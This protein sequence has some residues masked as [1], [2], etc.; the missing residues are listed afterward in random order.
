MMRPPPPPPPQTATVYDVA[1]HPRLHGLGIGR[2]LV[3]TIVAQLHAMGIYDIGAVREMEILVDVPPHTH[4]GYTYRCRLTPAYWSI[5]TR[6][7]STC[8]YPQVG[9][10]DLQNFFSRCSFGEDS[11]AS[12]FMAY[13]G[14]RD[15]TPPRTADGSGGPPSR[16]SGPGSTS[17]TGMASST[18]AANGALGWRDPSGPASPSSSAA[19]RQ[20]PVANTS[21][22]GAVRMYTSRRAAAGDG[23]RW[24]APDPGVAE[25]MARAGSGAAS[26]MDAF[27][28]QLPWNWDPAGQQHGRSDLNPLMLDCSDGRADAGAGTVHGRRSGGGWMLSYFAE[29]SVFSGDARAAA[30]PDDGEHGGGDPSGWMLNPLWGTRAAAAVQEEG[31]APLRRGLQAAGAVEAASSS[32]LEHNLGASSSSDPPSGRGEAA[33]RFSAAASQL[34]CSEALQQTLQRKLAEALGAADVAALSSSYAPA[35]AE[36]LCRGAGAA[37]ASAAPMAAEVAV[38]TTSAGALGRNVDAV[39][40]SALLEGAGAAEAPGS[41]GGETMDAEAAALWRSAAVMWPSPANRGI[42]SD[43]AAA[44]STPLPG[45]AYSCNRFGQHNGA[46]EPKY[47]EVWGTGFGY[48]GS[49]CPTSAAYNSSS[50]GR[51]SG[52][53]Y[54]G[55]AGGAEGGPCWSYE[56]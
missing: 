1:V 4:W 40:G 33:G 38:R 48:F 49:S 37:R 56:I 9:S 34:V 15:I 47:G 50:S 17:G 13:T 28:E 24:G 16:E 36:S 7:W 26:R 45:H 19:D 20:V 3:S 31:K 22:T 44:S 25:S 6:N 46:E 2:R 43:A 41:F 30:V 12:T 52:V 39:R 23:I 8:E 10:P 27:D 14:P 42:A 54:W 55:D 11:Q 21:S 51:G 18:A 29:G 32:G 5:F 53:P 35:A